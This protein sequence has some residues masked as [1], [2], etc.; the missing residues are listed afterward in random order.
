MAKVELRKVHLQV[1]RSYHEGGPRLAQ[2][3]LKGAVAAVVKNPFAGRYEPDLMPFMEAL[4]PLAVEIAGDL[5]RALGGDAGKIQ[6][7]GKGAIVGVS[8]ELEHAALWHAPG[9]AGARAVLGNPK[10]MVPASK[11]VGNVGTQLDIPTLHIHAAYVRSHYDVVPL[12]VPESPRP[13]EIVY[14]LVMTTG[15]RIHARIG[16]YALADVKGEDG[17]R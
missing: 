11:K 17:L 10:A 3:T 15:S 1:D 4:G 16:G 7:Y 9:G 2:P 12:V 8:G 14:A 13:D 5:L 6:G